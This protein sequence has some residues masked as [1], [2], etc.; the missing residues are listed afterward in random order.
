MR[1]IAGRYPHPL[2]NSEPLSTINIRP[3]TPADIPAIYAVNQVAFDGEAEP[4]LV[5][6]IRL[7]ENFIP[8]LS[9]VAEADGQVVGHI[10]FSRILIQAET[11]PI[12]ALSLA[13]MAV[14][15]E[16]Q[17]RGLG[18][19]LVRHGLD[20]SRRLGH[21]IVIVL[22]HPGYYPRFGFE[23]AEPLGIMPPYPVEPSEAWMVVELAPG[24]LEKAAGTVRVAEALMHEEMWR[25]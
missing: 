24:T 11:G 13:P 5:D 18:S 16:Y 9:L 17:N 23:P 19:A 22:G 4:R 8:E 20:E 10:L 14:L 25:E 3:E 12:P 6:A 2:K 7:S 15:P 1:A 21:S